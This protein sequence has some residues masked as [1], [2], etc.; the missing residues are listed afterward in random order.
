[1]QGVPCDGEKAKIVAS[2][3]EP[4]GAIFMVE[5]P[6]NSLTLKDIDFTRD[7]ASGPASA[8]RTTEGGLASDA[9]RLSLTVSDCTFSNFV[10]KVSDEVEA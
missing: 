7:P 8:I 4:T 5:G 9:G 1:M 3:D 2:M 6:E 10:T